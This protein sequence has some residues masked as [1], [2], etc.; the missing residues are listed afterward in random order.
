MIIDLIEMKYLWNQRH[1]A[2]YIA[3]I[4]CI[5]PTGLVIRGVL[6]YYTA[7]LCAPNTKTVEMGLEV[8]DTCAVCTAQCARVHARRS[9]INNDT[10]HTMVGH[11]YPHISAL[12]NIL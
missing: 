2:I 6:I 5:P 3:G 1:L 4:L 11:L 9:H 7:S 10:G 12:I 8:C